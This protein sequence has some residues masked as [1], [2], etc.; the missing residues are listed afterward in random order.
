MTCTPVTVYVAGSG[1]YRYE[2][3]IEQGT[4]AC[5]D[6]RG[7][8]RRFILDGAAAARWRCFRGHGGDAWAAACSRGTIV[9]RAYGPRRESDPWRIAAA[10]LAMP[11]LQPRPTGLR[12]RYVH[13]HT[14]FNCGPTKEEVEAEY[15]GPAGAALHVIE[16]K[17]RVCG[18]IGDARLVLTVFG[19]RGRLYETCEPPG[20][21]AK[22]GA[23]LLI[24]SRN[25]VQIGLQTT[26]IGV[27]G[28]LDAANSMQVV[29]V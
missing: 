9:V 14:N 3:R 20:C 15:A 12:L 7:V 24:F 4:V 10:R 11:V 26:H 8:L 6:A 27:K 5:A 18:D 1:T 21:G 13:T 16:G 29:A 25:G 2:V 17:P 28:L 19:G 23:Y 22:Q